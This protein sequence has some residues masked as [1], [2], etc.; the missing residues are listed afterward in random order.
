MI[1]IGAYYCDDVL[2]RGKGPVDPGLFLDNSVLF[3]HPKGEGVSAA[4]RNAA[5]EAETVKAARYLFTY[6][7]GWNSPGGGTVTEELLRELG[8]LEAVKRRISYP[9]EAVYGEYSY[10]DY[11]TSLVFPESPVY[12]R[13]KAV[14]SC[15]RRVLSGKKI[16]DGFFGNDGDSA[17][18]AKI[19]LLYALDDGGFDTVGKK[20]GVLS[21]GSALP[22][23]S[24]RKLRKYCEDH[25]V[26]PVDFLKSAL[27]ET[28][29]LPGDSEEE[30]RKALMIIEA[31]NRRTAERHKKLGIVG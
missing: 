22:W 21:S 24:G 15:Y 16:P 14:I 4:K 13:K 28:D 9:P 25:F 6:Y 18:R 26:R 8:I 2:F 11:F 23:L 7:L 19:C 10:V 20:Y 31:R 27:A 12:D 29:I 3:G 5:D 30:Y 1:D 17:Y